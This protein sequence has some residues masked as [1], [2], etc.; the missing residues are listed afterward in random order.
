MAV[1]AMVR[2]GQFLTRCSL[3]QFVHTN[4]PGDNG[5]IS[6]QTALPFELAENSV[7][8]GH[9]P[10]QDLGDNILNV[11]RTERYTAQVRCVV[12]DVIEKAEIAIDEIVPRA[13]LVVE[14]AM[15]QSAVNRSQSH[16]FTPGRAGEAN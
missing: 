7:I 15:E 5:Q 8:V 14:A 9:H 6:R 12:N 4:A 11:F 1:A 13:K 10:K 3:G 16:R 2:L